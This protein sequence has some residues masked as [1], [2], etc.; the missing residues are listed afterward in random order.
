M[1]NFDNP[2][3]ISPT[4]LASFNGLEQ[5]CDQYN[6]REQL[7]VKLPQGPLNSSEKRCESLEAG[8]L[9]SSTPKLDQSGR[10]NTLR[11]IKSENRV[12]IKQ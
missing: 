12:L 5:F 11:S 4:V 2:G 8:S 1:R 7:Q 9:P 6:N 10:V 3:V